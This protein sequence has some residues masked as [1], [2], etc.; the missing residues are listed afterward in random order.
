MR[1]REFITLLGSAFAI[2]PGAAIRSDGSYTAGRSTALSVRRQSGSKGSDRRSSRGASKAWLDRGPQHTDRSA[3]CERQRRPY[4]SASGGTRAVGSRRACRLCYGIIGG[5]A[6]GDQHHSHRVRTGNRSGRGRLREELGATRREHHRVYA[7]RIFNR[8]QMGGVAQRACAANRAGRDHLRSAKSRERPDTDRRL[9]HGAP[10][11]RVQISEHPVRDAAEI[12]RA[13]VPRL[14]AD[15]TV[16]LSYCRVPLHRSSTNW[17]LRLAN[18]HRLPAVYPFRYW[19]TSGGLAF[20]GIDNI[21]CT[22]RPRPMWIAYSRAKSRAICRSRT[23]PNSSLSSISRLPRHSASSRR[24]AC[25][26]ATDE[27]IE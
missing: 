22:G 25:W 17:S 5:F 24:I 2:V 16:V 1:R 8:R 19:V 6:K 3:L 11:F 23:R 7:A 10:P 26:R 27:V 9:K 20:Y 21:D 14:R 15:Q 13:V 4:A 18:Q 12:E